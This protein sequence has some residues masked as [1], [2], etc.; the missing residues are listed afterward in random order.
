[1]FYS[2]EFK[3]GVIKKVLSPGGP[4]ITR[5]SEE[6]GLGHCTISRWIK[7]SV[8]IRPMS[9]KKIQKKIPNDRPAAEKLRLVMEA[10]RLADDE[11]GEFLRRNGIHKSQLEQWESEALYGLD[12]SHQRPS[13]SQKKEN[14]KI[15]ELE[16]EIRRKD[17][18]LAEA[19]ALLILKKK[20]QAIWGDEDGNIV[21]WKD[22]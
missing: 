4:S 5:L 10:G 17:K 19:A 18:A 8:N 2:E 9:R 11:L 22:K 6:L 14:K 15:K 1:M 13:S 21:P 12:K 16:R 7:K 3:Q 20:A